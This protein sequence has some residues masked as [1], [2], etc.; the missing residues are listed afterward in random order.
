MSNRVPFT[1]RNCGNVETYPPQT[2]LREA[3]EAPCIRCGK[4]G[5]LPPK[6]VAKKGERDE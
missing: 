3:L 5:K 4:T 1:C 6:L 2:R